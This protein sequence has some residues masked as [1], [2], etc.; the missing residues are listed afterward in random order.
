MEHVKC[1]TGR[2]N[3]SDNSWQTWNMAI[4]IM[5]MVISSSISA[6]SVAGDFSLPKTDGLGELRANFKTPPPG[7]GMVPFHWWQGEPL[8]MDRLTWQLDKLK[9]FGCAGVQVNHTPYSSREQKATPTP[10]SPKW[11][12]FWNKSL[13][14]FKKR[15]MKVGMDDWGFKGDNWD[16]GNNPDI[17]GLHLGVLR[18]EGS[19]GQKR[20]ITIPDGYTPL[21]A[22]AYLVRDGKLD[23]DS[24]VD[25]FDEIDG[26][27]LELTAPEGPDK[28]KVVVVCSHRAVV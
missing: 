22:Q 5:L 16:L 4:T 2:I 19:N 7:Y 18:T 20:T 6:K 14:E 11:W 12:E 3:L 8:D 15:E 10:M 13:K 23:P 21:T 1:K 17:R 9:E 27:T 26:K 28:W 25:V 24:A